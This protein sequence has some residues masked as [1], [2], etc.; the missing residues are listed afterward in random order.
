MSSGPVWRRLGGDPL[1]LNE[2]D[3]VVI[4]RFEPEVAEG[5]GA[6]VLGV[7][8]MAAMQTYRRESIRLITYVW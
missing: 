2:D 8:S 5:S 6:G 3:G 1:L 7:G 4:S